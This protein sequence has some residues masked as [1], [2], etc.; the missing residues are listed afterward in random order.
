VAKKGRQN[1]VSKEVANPNVNA[2]AQDAEFAS[3]FAGTAKREKRNK[4]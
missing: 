1:K 2:H 3:E 4:K